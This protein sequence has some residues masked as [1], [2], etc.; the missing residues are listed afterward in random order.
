MRRAVAIAV[1]RGVRAVRQTLAIAAALGAAALLAAGCAPP[2]PPQTAGVPPTAIPGGAPSTGAPA[3]PLRLR[4]EP[5]LDIGLA[6]DRDSLVLQPNGGMRASLEGSHRDQFDVRG[7][8][9]TIV[10]TA[11]GA[12][13]SGGIALPQLRLGDTLIVGEPSDTRARITWNGRTWR[14]A[15]KVFPNV[16]GA[17]T[18]AARVPLETYLLGVVPGEIGQLA[19]NLIEAGRAQAI[20]ARS[21]TLY[22]QGRRGL[23]GF[24]LYGTVED[25]VYGALESER[26]LATRVVQGTRGMVALSQGWP[27]RANYY[28]TCGGITAEVWEAWPEPPKAY[29]VSHRD[30][31]NGGDFCSQSPVFRWREAWGAEEL[32]DNIG[33][34]GPTFG[35]PLPAGGVGEIVDARVTARTRSGRVWRLEVTTTTG[36]I[37][38][39]GYVVRQVLRR[40]G[41]PEAILRSSLF[42]L[43]VQRDAGSRRAETVIASGAG[44]GHGVGLCQ[45]GALGMARQGYRAEQIVTHYYP[46]VDLTRMY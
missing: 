5:T 1:A 39:P 15:L 8:A 26:P 40:A 37:E 34:Y 12:T 16:H 27:I 35:V 22:Y 46:G 45:T 44:F 31:V 2:P 42:K 17:L 36:R 4:G 13:V 14:G 7:G 24:D 23:E 20:A 11:E 38:I 21:F 19:P 32:A 6:W 28:S 30:A 41:H 43:D 9:I 25:Q 3:G 29:L 10:H 18:L 33:H